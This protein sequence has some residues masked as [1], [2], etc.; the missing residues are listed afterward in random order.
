MQ[1]KVLCRNL[2]Y[3]SSSIKDLPRLYLRHQD[4]LF[5]RT[6]TYELVG[7]TGSFQGENESFTFASYL[8][9]VSLFLDYVQSDFLN[10]AMNSDY[11]IKTQLEP[12]ITQQTGQA[13]FNGIKL[14]N[15]MFPLPPREQQKRIVAKVDQL[16]LLCDELEAK[17]TQ[18]QSNS[19]KLMNAA[20]R[21]V[22]GV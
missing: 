20:V 17:L 18:P 11:Y 4:I 14:A 12:E 3:V 21:Q 9:R 5:N 10:I 22:L 13:N 2:K 8:I 7:T 16:M 6:N 19:E 1:R 15:T